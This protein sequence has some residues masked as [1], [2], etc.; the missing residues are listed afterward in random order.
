MIEGTAKDK[1][2][3]GDSAP[4]D[5]PPGSDTKRRYES[6]R[7]GVIP[8]SDRSPR[9]RSGN[10]RAFEVVT[11]AV[12][13]AIKSGQARR[14]DALP[15]ERAMAEALGVS[16]ASVREGIRVLEAMGIVQIS[17]GL[18]PGGGVHIRQG[19]GGQLAEIIEMWSSLEHIDVSE[20][21]AFREAIESWACQSNK[22]GSK[23]RL[24]AMEQMG[25][26]VDRMATTADRGAY[27]DLDADFH[28]ELV[29]SSGNRLAALV[30]T[31]V[32]A[33]IRGHMEQA[34]S[35]VSDWDRARDALTEEHR[36]IHLA[37]GKGE[38]ERASILVLRHV[39]AFYRDYLS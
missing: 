25:L 15:A 6:P 31:A 21:I 38:L 10:Q 2:H 36:A 22:P 37:L 7:T 5:A 1:S 4:T 24:A 11:A 34:A 26:I 27:L 33:S 19:P 8:I 39:R 16:R 14:G 35:K 28:S 18:G 20:T 3:D 30:A 17:S 12:K 9:V 23:S 13:E 32:R 29:R